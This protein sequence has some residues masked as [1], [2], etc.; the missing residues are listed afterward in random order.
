MFDLGVQG[1]CASSDGPAIS[2]FGGEW[3]LQGMNEDLEALYSVLVNEIGAVQESVRV[4]RTEIEPKCF[5]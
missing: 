2:C 3:M 5:I 1:D 4:E